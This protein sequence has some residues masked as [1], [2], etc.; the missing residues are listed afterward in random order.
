MAQSCDPAGVIVPHERLDPAALAAL[1]EELVTR[2]GTELSD[3][4]AKVA[5]V[6]AALAAGELVI[7]W[8]ETSETCALLAPDEAERRI[9]EAARYPA[10][11]TS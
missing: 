1:I 10:D 5:R 2:D 9:R 11:P 7:V 8:E 3:A 6:R 4:T